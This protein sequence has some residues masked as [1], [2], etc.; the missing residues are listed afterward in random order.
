MTAAERTKL[1]NVP[2]DTTSELTALSAKLSSND[3]SLDD[4][5]DLVDHSK[6]IKSKVDN[7][8][9]DDK[10]R[11]LLLKINQCRAY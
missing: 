1:S 8:T 6:G 5:Q 9:M 4:L 3:S 10:M 11:L 2:S 7:L